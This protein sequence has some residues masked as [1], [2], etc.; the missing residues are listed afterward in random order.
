[1]LLFRQLD[2]LETVRGNGDH[3][4]IIDCGKHQA[5]IAAG[6]LNVIRNEHS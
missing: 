4:H 6:F 3:F 5:R 2:G 1:M